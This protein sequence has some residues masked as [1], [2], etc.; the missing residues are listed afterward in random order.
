MTERERRSGNERRS[1]SP[2]ETHT[3]LERLIEERTAQLQASE[4]KLLERVQVSEKARKAMLYMLEDLNESEKALLTS[5]SHLKKALEGTITAISKAVEA[6]DPYTAGHQR[7]VADLAV[8]IAGEIG[9]SEDMIEG[10]LL[11]A[12]IHDIGKIH[13]PAEILSKPA[14]LTDLEYQ[15]I[16][17]HAQIGYDILQEIDFPWPIA[18]IA[19]QHHEHLDGSGYP[20]GLKGEEICLEARIVAVAD[21]VEAMASH[22]PYRPSLGIDMALDE[23]KQSRGVLYD[24]VVVDACLKIF[25]EKSYTLKDQ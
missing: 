7:R 15:L 8:A 9:C 12:S 11:G 5:H 25:L 13:M 16:Q 1:E 22:R 23:L 10:I 19:H 24:P 2:Q 14:K 6:R 21:T 17:N 3:R 4:E 18:D 20:Q